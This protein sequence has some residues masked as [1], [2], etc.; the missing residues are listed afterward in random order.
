[1]SIT[2]LPGELYTHRKG[3]LV[4]CVAT[5]EATQRPVV[6]YRSQETR[7]YWTRP[8][9]EFMDGRFTRASDATTPTIE[10]GQ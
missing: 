6:V 4:V 9:G 1:M 5:E 2:P 10:P 3:G 7:R 8:L